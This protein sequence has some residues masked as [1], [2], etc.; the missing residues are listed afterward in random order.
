MSEIIDEITSNVID[1]DI[2][3]NT[4]IV[5]ARHYDDEDD[6]GNGYRVLFLRLNN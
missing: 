4:L 1:I 2:S 5:S 3:D 6:G